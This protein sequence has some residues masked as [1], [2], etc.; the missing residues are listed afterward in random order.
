[1]PAAEAAWV[2]RCRAGAAQTLFPQADSWINGANIPG[3]PKASMFFMEG[4]AAYMM[5]LY[6]IVERDYAPFRF[7][8]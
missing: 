4:M 1:M 5:A 6:A 2:E 8:P 7:A 3:K